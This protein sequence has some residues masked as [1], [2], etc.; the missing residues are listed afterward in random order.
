MTVTTAAGRALDLGVITGDWRNTNPEG[1]LRRIVCTAADGAL[2]VR[3]DDR[4]SVAAQ[5]YSF[6]FEEPVAGAFSVELALD[7]THLRL[8]AHVKAGVLVV[9]VLTEFRDGSGRA[10]FFNREFFHRVS[11]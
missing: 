11:G 6:T 1:T 4:E 2:E 10:N 8:Q 5:I 9:V 7:G 3:V